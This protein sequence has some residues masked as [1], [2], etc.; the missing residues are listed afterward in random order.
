MNRNQFNVELLYGDVEAF[1]V[2]KVLVLV[3]L[4]IGLQQAEELA[5]VQYLEVKPPCDAIEEPFNCLHL[6]WPTEDGM[7]FSISSS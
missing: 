5:F 2:A 4:R 7:D 3:H 1:W 6:S